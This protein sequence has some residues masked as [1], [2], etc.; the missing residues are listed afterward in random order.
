MQLILLQKVEN[1]GDEG[2]VIEVKKDTLEII[3]F[4]RNWRLK[5]PRGV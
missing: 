5:R 4:Q 1:L 2:D 3:S